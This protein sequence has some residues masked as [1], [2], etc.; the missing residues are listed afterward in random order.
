MNPVSTERA[1]SGLLE[2]Y[3]EVIPEPKT[4]WV[5]E[6]DAEIYQQRMGEEQVIWRPIRRDESQDFTALESALGISFHDSVKRLFG[7]WF[8]GDLSLIFTHDETTQPISFELLMPQCLEDADRLLQNLT[9]HILM[10][11]KLKQPITIFIGILHEHDDC[12]VSVDNST[13]EVALEW[14][15]KLQHQTLA[16][17]LATFLSHCQPYCGEND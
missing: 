15:G 9:G 3:I 11:R 12:L 8:S 14:L 1:V 7:D 5:E 4:E 6:W 16:V 13:G 17:D 2:R 10:K